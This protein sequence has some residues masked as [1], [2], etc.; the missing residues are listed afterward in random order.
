MTDYYLPKDELDFYQFCYVDSS[1]Q[2]CG[3]STPF[4]FKAQ[5]VN[6]E[7]SAANSSDDLLVITTQVHTQRL[8]S[9]FIQVGTQTWGQLPHGAMVVCSS[10]I[11]VSSF[12]CLEPGTSGAERSGDCVAEGRGPSHPT[13]KRRVGKSSAGRETRSRRHEGL[14]ATSVMVT[15]GRQLTVC[16]T[17]QTRWTRVRTASDEREQR[18]SS[19]HF[20]GATWRNPTLKGFICP[21]CP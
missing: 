4:S 9:D 17:G 18:E 8:A 13:A 6:N 3:A 16:F 21:L 20:A 19:V 5:D 12:F 2:V 7:Q 1:G 15:D 10:H 14:N 11:G